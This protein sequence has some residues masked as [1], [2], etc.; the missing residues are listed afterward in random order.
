MICCWN[1]SKNKITYT[2]KSLPALSQSMAES[3]M[4]LRISD[5]EELGYTF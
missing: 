5:K 2:K 3:D 1:H 4:A